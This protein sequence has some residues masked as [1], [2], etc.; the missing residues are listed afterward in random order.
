MKPAWDQLMDEFKDSKT[1]LVADVDCTVE[2]S[3]CS[4]HG[5]QGYP[6]IKYG[7]PD[8][9]EDYNGGRSFDD[10][11]TFASENL[12]PTCG[13]D[14]LD[15]CSDDQKAEIA[16]VMA[17]SQEDRDAKIAA[18]EKAIADAEELFNS[19]VEKLQ[20]KYEQ[21][22]EEKEATVKAAKAPL[23]LLKQANKAAKK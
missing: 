18:G 13:P 10:L 15:L 21:L 1:A 9:L 11:K 7:S 22:S 23:G 16:K 14:N 8:A 2:E 6:T 17:M 4:T 20:K 3:L 12:G 5:V 19:E